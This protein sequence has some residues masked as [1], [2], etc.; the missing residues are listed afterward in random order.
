[1]RCKRH[2]YCNIGW[3]QAGGEHRCTSETRVCVI[4]VCTERRTFPMI[5][6]HT[7]K[8]Q[9]HKSCPPLYCKLTPRNAAGANTNMQHMPQPS[10]SKLQPSRVNSGYQH[11]GGK[12]ERPASPSQALDRNLHL[13]RC[14]RKAV[15]TLICKVVCAH[16][17]L[18]LVLGGGVFVYARP[19]IRGIPP[20]GDVQVFEEQVHA[21]H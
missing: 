19:V 18:L 1:M 13:H 6:K 7:S 8:H 16:Q 15:K 14:V 12:K 9:K 11:G 5:T 17:L 2:D 21:R 3:C 4:S 10:S 20:E